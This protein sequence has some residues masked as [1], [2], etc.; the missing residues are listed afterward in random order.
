MDLPGVGEKVADCVLLFSLGF[1]QAFPVDT[2]IKKGMEEEYF[3]GQR[4]SSAKIGAFAREYFGLFAG[5]A[6][7]YL[8]HYWR[9]KARIRSGI[10]SR[11]SEAR[12]KAKRE[13]TSDV[14]PT[15]STQLTPGRNR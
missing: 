7:Q 6:Q 15:Q 14:V 8:Y 13:K 3:R 11:Q 9:E 2:W 12:I 10:R 4:T 1:S 5:Y